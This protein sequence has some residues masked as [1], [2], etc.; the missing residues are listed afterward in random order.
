MENFEQVAK[1]YAPMISRVLKTAR[2]YKNHDYY[3]HCAMIG[4]WEAVRRYDAAKGEFAPFAFRTMLTK[5]YKEMALENKHN[6]HYIPYEKEELNVLA[7]HEEVTDDVY[8]LLKELQEIL[9]LSAMEFQLLVDLYY[10]RF[11]YDELAE[12][13]QAKKSALKKR[14]DRL[15]KKIREELKK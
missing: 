6:E 5:I 2:V 8:S 4:L 14:R 15:M 3:R 11:T 13:Y 7:Q 12:K 1:Q 10:H 9:T